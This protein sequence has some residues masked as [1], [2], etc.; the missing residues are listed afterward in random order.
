MN[1]LPYPRKRPRYRGDQPQFWYYENYVKNYAQLVEQK[2]ITRADVARMI[3]VADDIVSKMHNAYRI[4]KTTAIEREDW[5]TPEEAIKSLQK[6]ED[7]RVCHF[8]LFF[9]YWDP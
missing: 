7:F 6:F 1:L 4:D 9:I 3:S 8:F 2:K 5:S